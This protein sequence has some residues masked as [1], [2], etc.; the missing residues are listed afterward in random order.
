MDKTK[1]SDLQRLDL[2]KKYFYGGFALL[3]FLWAVN[4]VWFFTDAFVKAE[5][6]QQREVKKYVIY[7]SVGALVWT[8][9][10]ITWTVIYQQ[11]RAAWGEVGD[12][13]SFV[14]PRGIP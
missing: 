10:L 7:S 9:V 12:Q 4:A 6:P 5:Y 11:N 13:L 3:P 8:V 1:L 2:C 14:I